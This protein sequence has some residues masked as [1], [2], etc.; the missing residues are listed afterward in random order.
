[1]YILVSKRVHPDIL[2]SYSQ[3]EIC[4][5]AE[6]IT[7]PIIK[8]CLKQT[9]LNDHLVVLSYADIGART[10]LGSSGSFTVGLLNSLYG[11]LGKTIEKEELAELACHIQMN[12]LNQPSGK[13]DEYIATYGGIQCFD[14]AK[15]GKV[16]V[17]PLQI[18]EYSKNELEK[19]L[20][21]FDTGLTRS[22][23]NILED[24]KQTAHDIPEK[25]EHL[26]KIKNLGLRTKTELEKGNVDEFGHIMN[27]HWEAKKQTSQKIS[28]SSIDKLYETTK[29]LGAYGGKLIGA[30]GGGIF[31]LYVNDKQSKKDIRR[32]FLSHEMK[33]IF[34]PFE[35]NGTNNIVNLSEGVQ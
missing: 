33:E 1:M 8:E 11:Y 18:S 4:D 22:A 31:M 9:N 16:S 20:L 29:K 19:N 24:Q 27:E 23:S 32:E 35:S 15:N 21:F 13:Q 14:I 28:N 17:T 12:S 5:T 2:L 3:Y 25:I 7:H 6:K 34:L 26:R 30:G 10:G